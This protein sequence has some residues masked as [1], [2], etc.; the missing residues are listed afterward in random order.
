[1]AN[2]LLVKLY[3]L[4]PLQ[5]EF[6]KMQKAGV[7]IRRPIGPENYKVIAWITEHFGEGW[8]GESENAFFNNPKSIFI[9]IKD[10]KM[11]GFACYDATVKGFFGP[12]GVQED[13]RGL[14]IG[15]ALLIYTLHGLKDAGY[16]YGVIGSPGPVE[17]YVKALGAMEIPCSAPGVYKG[18]L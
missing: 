6:E 13:C 10:E 12:T 1:M 5:P 8:A 3:E 14:G 7:I 9:A 17:F 15:K 16:G 2:D 18:M 4:P 11:V